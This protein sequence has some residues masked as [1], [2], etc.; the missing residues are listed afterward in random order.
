MAFVKHWLAASALMAAAAGAHAQV[1]QIA[2]E[3]GNLYI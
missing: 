3:A 1:N 2:K